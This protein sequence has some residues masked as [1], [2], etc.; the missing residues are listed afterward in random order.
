MPRLKLLATFRA[1]VQATGHRGQQGQG[2]VEYGLIVA[3][4]SM[5]LVVALTAMNGALSTVFGD[6]VTAIDAVIP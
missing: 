1:V 2:L 6:V 5:A 3:L 4:V